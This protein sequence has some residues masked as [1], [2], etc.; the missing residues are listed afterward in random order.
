MILLIRS[1]RSSMRRP[2][3]R[4]NVGPLDAPVSVLLEHLAEPEPEPEAEAEAKLDAKQPESPK[5]KSK[6]GVPD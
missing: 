4:D 3:T 6:E 5:P 2:F 1:L